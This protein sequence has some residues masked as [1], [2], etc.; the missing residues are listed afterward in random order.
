MVPAVSAPLLEGATVDLDTRLGGNLVIDNPNTPS[1]DIPGLAEAELTG[2]VEERVRQVIE[3]FVNP[4]IASHNGSC[5]LVAVEGD[6]AHVRLGGGCTGCGMAAVTLR[7]GIEAAIERHGAV[8]G[9]PTAGI[10]LLENPWISLHDGRDALAVA[11]GDRRIDIQLHSAAHELASHRL[12]AGVVV[13]LLGA[14]VVR[15]ERERR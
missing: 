8:Q 3:G 11:N 14:D 7:Q 5:E 2:T 13:R 4:A 10:A 9:R 12:K 1:P 6:E 15:R